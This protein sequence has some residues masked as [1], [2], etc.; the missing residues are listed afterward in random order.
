MRRKRGT[1]AVMG[2]SNLVPRIVKRSP[3]RPGNLY[4]EN[5]YAARAHKVRTIAVVLR[6]IRRLFL[7]LSRIDKLP[8][9][10]RIDLYASRLGL[11]NSFGGSLNIS[12]L[13]LNEVKIIQTI[14]IRLQ[15][16]SNPT[17]IAFPAEPTSRFNLTIDD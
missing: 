17:A 2:G 4:L 12:T 5:A 9:G 3:R 13:F 6:E 10:A 15:N 16:R 7:M 14:G 11:K 8:P 1:N